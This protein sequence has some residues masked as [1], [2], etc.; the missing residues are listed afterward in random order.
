MCRRLPF[1]TGKVGG[2]TPSSVSVT[3][4]VQEKGGCRGGKNV[5]GCGAAYASKY[6]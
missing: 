4:G 5:G 6:I 1:L 3:V 2:L